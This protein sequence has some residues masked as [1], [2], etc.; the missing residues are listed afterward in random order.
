MA[1]DV[2]LII[3]GDTRDAETALRELARTGGQAASILE[4][5]FQQL[6]TKSTIAFDNQRK[7]AQDAY[8]RIKSSGFATADELKRA[9]KNLGDEMTRIDEE[10]YGKRTTLAQK[11]KDNWLNVTAAISAGYMVKNFAE[12]AL[13]EFKQ[14][15]SALT[16]MAKVTAQPLGEIKKQIM[17]LPA[18]LGSATELMKGYYEIM[19]AGVAEPAKAMEMLVTASKAGKAAHIDQKTVVEALTKMMA[20][21]GDKIKS[22]KEAS[23]LLFTIEKVG[24]TTFAAL[25]PVIGGLASMSAQ[26]R[27]MPQEMGGVLAQLTQTA[28][29]TSQAATQFEAIMSGFIKPTK[30][31]AET[32]KALGY[33]SGQALIGDKGLTGALMAVKTAAESSFGPQGLGKL[34]ESKEALIGLGPLFADSF[35][36][37]NQAIKDVGNSAGA[38]DAAFERWKVTLD[39]V[40]E[41]FKNTVGKVMIEIGEKLAPTVMSA[42]TGLAKW[43]TDNKAGI[44]AFFEGIMAVVN[45]VAGAINAVAGALKP[46]TEL[47]YDIVNSDW[48][49]NGGLVGAVSG[50][51]SGPSQAT[52]ASPSPSGVVDINAPMGTYSM[53]S[54]AVGT[55]YVPRTGLYQ[56]HRGEEVRTRGEVA[57]GGGGSVTIAPVIN[58]SGVSAAGREK[59]GRELARELL[60]EL[61]RLAP[62]FA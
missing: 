13:N 44:V 61:Q 42:L 58:I 6:G 25:A 40:E 23:D 5:E 15:E 33:E 3:K 60:P 59:T 8:A 32:L 9:H 39:G 57:K 24:Q 11:F 26:L 21:F 54:W 49:K 22:A 46:V 43:M 17:E 53:G 2:R 30:T 45:G 1:K 50:A 51:I 48:M 14:F 38:T 10:Q 34:F 55:A 12:S 47:I 4:R 37:T 16:D 31:M 29:S 20:G 41:T 18:E 27:I 52:A 36:K 7:A 35:A 62:R 19:S 28:G 56:L